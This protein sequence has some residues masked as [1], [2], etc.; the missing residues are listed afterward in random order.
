MLKCR[1]KDFPHV[2][3]DMEKKKALKSFYQL[4]VIL[5][6]AYDMFVRLRDENFSN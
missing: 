4:L 3:M 1:D 6:H 5:K 2:F